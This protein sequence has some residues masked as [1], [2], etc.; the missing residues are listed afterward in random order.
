MSKKVP[1]LWMTGHCE[2]REREILTARR[3]TACH[4]RLACDGLLRQCSIADN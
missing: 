4:I 2:K 1:P 3:R